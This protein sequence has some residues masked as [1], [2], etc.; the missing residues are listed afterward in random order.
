MTEPLKENED[1]ELIPQDDDGWAVRILS[2]PFIETVVQYDTVK[3][4][5]TE[6]CLRYNF[7]ILSTPT[8]DLQKEDQEFQQHIANILYALLL[9]GTEDGSINFNQEI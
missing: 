6:G 5:G 7:N 3:I 1:F 8:P 2:G 4:D 9:Q